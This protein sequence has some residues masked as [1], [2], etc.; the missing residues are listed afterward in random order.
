LAFFLQ[1]GIPGSWHLAP[2]LNAASL[3]PLCTHPLPSP[4]LPPSP[5]HP[6]E[7]KRRWVFGQPILQELLLVLDGTAFGGQVRRGR[8]ELSNA[9]RHVLFQKRN[10]RCHH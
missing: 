1:L 8:A 7:T 3:L 9:T 4:P 2:T 6:R 10:R 5:A